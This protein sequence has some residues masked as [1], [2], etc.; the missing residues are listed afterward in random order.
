MIK[1][2]RFLLSLDFL[3]CRIFLNGGGLLVHRRIFLNESS[4]VKWTISFFGNK[5]YLL[6]CESGTDSLG[7]IGLFIHLP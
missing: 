3:S 4:R 1:S 5:R 7:Q 6:F 2:V